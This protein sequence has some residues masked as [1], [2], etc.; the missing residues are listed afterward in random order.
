MNRLKIIIADPSVVYMKMFS[1]ALTELSQNADIRQ[2]SSGSEILDLIRQSDYNV[3]VLDADI[4]GS[5]SSGLIRDVMRVIPKLLLLF[6]T[7][8]TA[9]SND[10]CA[11][12][13]TQGAFDIMIKPIA[14]SY[15][16]NYDMVKSKLSDILNLIQN[17]DDNRSLEA[18]PKAMVVKNGRAKKDIKPD[19]IL[20]AASTGG[21]MALERIITEL[22]AGFPVPMIVVQHMP[23]HF[24]EVLASNLNQKSAVTVK[25]AEHGDVAT[26]GTVYIAPGGKHIKLM[27]KSSIILDDSPP[28]GGF[29][30]AADVLF[31]SAADNLDGMLVWVIILTGMG[32]DGEKGLMRLKTKQNCF[33]IAQSKESCVIYGMPRAAVESGLADE[34]LSLDDIAAELKALGEQPRQPN[35]NE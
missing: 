12:A 15:D 28:S 17:E 1:K 23:V 5:V 26:A 13:L 21:P 3:V 27:T 11:K 22:G 29:R 18:K 20:I 30:P 32:N 10:L 14:K 6:T 25:T 9:V 19:I 24:I 35:P 8:P 7:Q 4:P 16:E 33:C 34:M 31:E 2:T